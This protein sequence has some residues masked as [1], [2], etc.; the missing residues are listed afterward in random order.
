MQSD[1]GSRIRPEQ[2]TPETRR[3]LQHESY[4]NEFFAIC[5]VIVPAVCIA[6]MLSLGYRWHGEPT[7][8]EWK[9]ILPILVVAA[10]IVIGVLMWFQRERRFL[11]RAPITV[12]EVKEIETS[13]DLTHTHRLVIKYKPLPEDAK[14]ASVSNGITDQQVTVALELDLKGFTDELHGGDAVSIL[15]D[16]AH[17]DHVRVVEEEQRNT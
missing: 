8:T 9:P 16:P 10:A 2:V 12:A 11:A 1:F 3:H 15:Y 13:Y 6:L 14:T 7:Y 5:C 4:V 17:P